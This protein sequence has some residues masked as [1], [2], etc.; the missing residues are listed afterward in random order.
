L[1]KNHRFQK[2]FTLI[3]LLVVVALIG[4]LSSIGIVSFQGFTQSAKQKNAELSL[5]TLN[6]GLQEYKSSFGSY[7]T[8]ASTCNAGSNALLV[9]N[10]L[11]GQDNLSDQDFQFCID[12]SGS[13][14]TI[15]AKN[16]KTGC[17]I[18]LNQTLKVSRNSSC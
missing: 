13:N 2:A 17:E 4:I 11:D 6:L 3:E 7:Y 1:V 12:A 8:G 16:P 10:I 5:N 14:Y 9:S 18:S 15:K